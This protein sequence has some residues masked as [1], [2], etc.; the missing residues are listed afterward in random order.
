M[1]ESE[2]STHSIEKLQTSGLT[3]ELQKETIFNKWYASVRKLGGP[4][5]G[6][7]R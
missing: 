4:T 1:N 2:I 5:S 3:T 7:N 6:I